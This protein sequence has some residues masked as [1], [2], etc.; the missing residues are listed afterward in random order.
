MSVTRRDFLM[1]VGLAGGYTAAFTM[2][3]SL[4]LLGVPRAMADTTKPNP[5]AGKGAKVVILG[6]GIAGLVAAYEL[7]KAGYAC[8]VLEARQRV[9]GR[10]WT[11]RNGTDVKFTDGSVQQCRF[12]E[13]HYFNA[14]PA[15]LP[16]THTTML[17]YCQELGVPL[18]VEIN[19]SRSALMQCDRLNGGKA[20]Q[21]RQMVNDT[22]G[23]VAE[24]LAKSLN[25]GALD[26][27][28]THD[29][30]E[31]ML[32]FLRQYGDLSPDLFFKGTERSGY[33]VFPGAGA[34]GPQ[35]KDPLDMTALLSANLWEGM[36]S[37]D[38]I[39]W[40]ATMFQPIGGMD[41]IP[42]AFEKRLGDVIRNGAE[43]KEI[44]QVSKGVRISYLETKTGSQRQIEADYCICAM[45]L[46]VLKGMDTDFGNDVKAVI[47]NSSYDSAYK[48]AWESRRFWEQ[49]YEI[50][51]GLSYLN[52]MVSVVWYPSWNL[53]SQK[54]V[55]VS[56]YGIENGSAFGKL[57]TREA[58][59]NAS[60]RAL[61]LLHPGHSNELTNPVYVS[62]GNIPYNLG[63]WISG[64]G[65]K[66]DTDIARLLEPDRRIFFA[67]DHT[68]HL[69]GWQEGAA[70]S[71][72]R[73]IGQISGMV[74]RGDGHA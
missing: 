48:I 25:K 42:S 69:V 56:G 12:E 43:V 74:E 67:G 39:D 46:S 54:G 65:R 4:G 62:W 59:V 70:L 27:E 13:G 7:G 73:A 49:E 8:T 44:R 41:R 1:R 37:E 23:H 30:K 52:Q 24:L 55:V 10:N 3:Q 15:R 18:E 40:Q 71:A 16:S 5:V 29:D 38:I 6:G 33:K 11:I 35:A 51:G 36:L 57:P 66:N 26:E 63:S 31:R 72:Y 61:E 50:Y 53:F 34:Q 32:E 64:F 45:P 20:V 9:G 47:D 2:M 58:K 19:T 60:R 17:G 28:L 21:L 22:R 14:G 68:S